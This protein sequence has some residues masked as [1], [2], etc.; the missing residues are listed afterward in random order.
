MAGLALGQY[1]PST[2]AQSGNIT[3]SLPGSIAATQ[4]V[5]P[6]EPTSGNQSML[7]P[8]KSSNLVQAI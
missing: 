7:Y 8:E 1:A 6:L 4:T 3:G 2:A 5:N